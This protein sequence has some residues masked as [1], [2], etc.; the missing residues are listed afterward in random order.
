MLQDRTLIERIPTEFREP[1]IEFIQRE[2]EREVQRRG[3]VREDFREL[4]ENLQRLEIIVEKLAQAQA[5]TEERVEELAQAQ[6][7]TEACLDRLEAAVEK[8]AQIQTRF[9][10]VFTARMGAL[11]AR[12]GLES[13]ASFR[14]GLREIL[15]DVGFQTQRYLTF[16]E[17]GI[18]FD[19]PAQVEL[20]V[21]VRDGKVFILEIKSSVS[22]GDVSV[23]AR[24]V[25]FYEARE[26]VTVD[27][28]ILLSPFVEERARDLALQ[29]GV[30]VISD[31]EE[32]AE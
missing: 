18:V 25:K 12:W 32:L 6:A 2:V 22:R 11:G 26:G 14:K 16:D 17:E 8:L 9:E 28:R 27:R 1:L 30:E 21:V 23:F 13:E 10:H 24:K 19:R 3:I 20:D 7:R 29:M 4:K 15:K 31:A 5:R